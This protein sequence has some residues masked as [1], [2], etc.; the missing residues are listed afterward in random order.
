MQRQIQLLQNGTPRQQYHAREQLKRCG[1][2]VEPALVDILRVT[3]DEDVARGILVVLAHAKMTQPQTV[4]VVLQA[5]GRSARLRA[6]G[7]NALLQASPKLRRHLPT[8]RRF[9]S[10]EIR[11]TVRDSL[12]KLIDRYPST[13]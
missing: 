8:L 11:P 3:T 7:A 12:Q 1:P 13:S 4:A 5:M 6:A 10:A 9:L 2:E